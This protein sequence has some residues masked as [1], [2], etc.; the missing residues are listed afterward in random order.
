MANTAVGPHLTK[1]KHCALVDDAVQFFALL[2]YVF[3]RRI[4][5]FLSLSHTLTAYLSTLYVS[6]RQ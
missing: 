6:V 4:L 5:V 1:P 2:K 3:S